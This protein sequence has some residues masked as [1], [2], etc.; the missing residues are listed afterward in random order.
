VAAK[1][2]AEAQN[3]LHAA[4][5]EKKFIY[6]IPKG[7]AGGGKGTS[8]KSTKRYPAMYDLAANKDLF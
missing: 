5:E 1:E 4:A 7:K 2:A 6:K 8:L 3:L